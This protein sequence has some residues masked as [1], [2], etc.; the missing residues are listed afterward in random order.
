MLYAFGD[1]KEPLEETV[2]I[3]DEITTDFVI[4]TSHTAA[5]V[6][7]YSG[8]AKIKN[9][10]F[11]FAIRKDEIATGR[12]RELQMME[13][14]L[15]EHRKQFDTGEGKIGLE[16]GGRKKVRVVVFYGFCS[17]NR[18]VLTCKLHFAYL[19][20]KLSLSWVEL[21]YNGLLEGGKTR[22]RNP[23]QHQGQAQRRGGGS[24]RR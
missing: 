15:K 4:E 6:A 2:R 19:S 8:R 20:S 3:L 17:G 16:R 22:R 18:L 7:E 23:G 12:V 9:D 21:T 1:D 11:M 24:S 13:K 10:D 14:H 5:R